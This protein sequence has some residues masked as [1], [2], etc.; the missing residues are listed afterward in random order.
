MSPRVVLVGAPGSG[1][2][3]VGRAVARSLGL[4][5][6]DTDADIEAA[7]GRSI[8]ELF[9]DEGESAFRDRETDALRI[10]LDECNGV[11]SLGGGVVLRDANRE[12]LADHTVVWL[13]VTLAD[14]ADRV[15]LATSRPV[16][17]GNVRGRLMELL[18]Q[19]TPLYGQVATHR[20][21]T[22]LKKPSEIANEIV[23]LLEVAH[24]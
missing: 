10:A 6:R 8:S 2:T 19:R 17:L 4:E 15:G 20:V 14:A 11:L 9:L 12:L 5:F 3:T 22:H 13:E 18:Q 21:S 16:L 23:A 24:G 7:T 1:K